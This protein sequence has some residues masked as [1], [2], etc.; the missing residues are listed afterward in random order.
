M[1]RKIGK[2]SL[3]RELNGKWT[4]RLAVD[5]R[6]INRSS[7]TRNIAEAK[8]ML[9]ELV[10]EQAELRAQRD[11][12]VK[13]LGEWDSIRQALAASGIDEARIDRRRIVWRD[14]SEWMHMKHPEAESHADVTEAVASEY[15]AETAEKLSASAR[16]A[17]LYALRGMFGLLCGGGDAPNPWRRVARLSEAPHNRRP[18]STDEIER[19]VAAA[20]EEGHEWRKLF[21]LGVNTGQN[22]AGCCAV[23]WSDIDLAERRIRIKGGDGA[24]HVVGMN[25]NLH[26][27]LAA[28]D[29]RARRGC[30]VPGIAE[31]NRRGARDVKDA[32]ARIFK[33]AGIETSVRVE[34]HSR[35]SPDASF[36]SLRCSFIEFAARSGVPLAEVK[37]IVNSKC[38]HI[39]KLYRKAAGRPRRGDDDAREDAYAALAERLGEMGELLRLGLVSRR[40]YDRTCR[41][42]C[43]QTR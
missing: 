40:E 24:F 28:T 16:N 20:G 31:M 1:H 2:G 37:A 32:L 36:L 29:E 19:L 42:M 9:R 11:A 5:G 6:T 8:T 15:L 4:L 7:G 43:R 30:V 41:R 12:S 34:G 21:L 25:A 33:R 23:S 27:A 3:Q 22:F 14:F 35:G 10:R 26:D 38:S 17:R 13:L 18:L 39:G